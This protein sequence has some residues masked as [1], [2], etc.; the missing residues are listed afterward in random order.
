MVIVTKEQAL[1]VFYCEPLTKFNVE[2]FSKII[3]DLENVE[4][5][6]YDDPK[7][8]FLQ[9]TKKQFTR[10][11]LKSIHIKLV[12]LLNL[13]YLPDDIIYERQL[14][15]MKDILSKVWEYSSLFDGDNSSSFNRFVS[16]NSNSNDS[17][18]KRDSNPN[19]IIKKLKYVDADMQELLKF[20][21]INSKICL[22]TLNSN[23]LK[24]FIK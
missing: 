17:L 18:I 11:P 13:I 16:I 21:V 8:P 24:N 12:Q 23:D 14:L 2:K 4:I 19:N 3:E 6:Y 5:C 10:N 22:V 1:C 9:C 7:R 15:S 20:V